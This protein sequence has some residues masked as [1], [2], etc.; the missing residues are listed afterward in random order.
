MPLIFKQMFSC[1]I[2]LKEYKDWVECPERACP[3][4]QDKCHNWAIINIGNKENEEQKGETKHSI[5][6]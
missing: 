1:R 3:D 5:I 4:C 6:N 2:C